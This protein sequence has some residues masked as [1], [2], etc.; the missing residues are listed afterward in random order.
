LEKDPV[1]RAHEVLVIG[2]SAGSLEVIM[3]MLPDLQTPL[4]IAIIVVV[5]RKY[6]AD[7][8]LSHLFSYKT[9]I[10]VK[11]IED[12]DPVLP[13]CIYVAPVDYHLLV[14]QDRVFS[15]DLSEKIH[16]SRPSIDITFECVSEVYGA[17]T[18][19]LLLSGANADGVH[20]MKL[21][22]SRGGITAVQDPATA[23]V[24]FMPE[25]ALTELASDTIL[26]PEEIAG[27]VNSL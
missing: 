19:C 20:G 12:K 6:V 25:L 24:P 4:K 5:H 15:L 10:P 7:S 18:A 9:A 11:E 23:M 21:V 8:S 27:F 2:G 17:K 13:G 16:Y 22:Q 1:E 14:E 26:R 3:S